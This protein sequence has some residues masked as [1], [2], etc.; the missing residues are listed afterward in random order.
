MLDVIE[1]APSAGGAS[2]ETS[3]AGCLDNL[4]N[5]PIQAPAQAK[6]RD[7]AEFDADIALALTASSWRAAAVLLKHAALLIE[8][9]D[10]LSAERNRRQ[11]REQ[12]VAAN[13]IFRQFREARASAAAAIGAEAFLMAPP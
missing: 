7:L 11:A 1:E 8:A 13:D 3:K 5:R 9:G 6:R 4:E 2:S 10:F 12:F